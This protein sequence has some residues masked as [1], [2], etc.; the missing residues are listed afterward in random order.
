MMHRLRQKAGSAKGTVPSLLA[1][2]MP[3]APFDSLAKLLAS[4]ESGQ[5]TGI[6]NHLLH[7]GTDFAPA[8]GCV[9]ILGWLG[10]HLK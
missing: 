8:H 9:I 4:L 7:R 10:I 6:F 3:T 2:R 5:I 1:T